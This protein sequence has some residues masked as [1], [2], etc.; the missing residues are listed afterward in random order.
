MHLKVTLHSLLLDVQ[1]V[2]WGGRGVLKK[3]LYMG[4]RSLYVVLP[5]HLDVS[6]RI[7]NSI[8]HLFSHMPFCNIH[9]SLGDNI[10]GSAVSL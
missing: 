3:R 1:G 7:K 4:R 10:T 8:N 2:R 9:V 5:P 6:K